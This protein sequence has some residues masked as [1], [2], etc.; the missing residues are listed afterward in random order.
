VRPLVG[1]Q[2]Q[3]PRTAVKAF[4]KLK[5]AR[6]IIDWMVFCTRFNL[7]SHQGITNQPPMNDVIKDSSYCNFP[8]CAYYWTCSGG[9][10]AVLLLLTNRF[11]FN[12]GRI[13]GYLAVCG[14]C[15]VGRRSFCRRGSEPMQAGNGR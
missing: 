5:S 7:N 6:F 13:G 10:A 15:I 14:R 12:G 8:R 2:V 4:H 1:L 9:A 3:G 11:A